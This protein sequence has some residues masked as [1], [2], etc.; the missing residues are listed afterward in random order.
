[1]KAEF[2]GQKMSTEMNDSG[3]AANNK[4]NYDRFGIPHVQEY[5]SMLYVVMA[6]VCIIC[7]LLM[8]YILV[9]MWPELIEL[10][11]EVL[12]M[13]PKLI[14]GALSAL[15]ILEPILGCSMPFIGSFVGIGS[16]V[17]YVK[18]KKTENLTGMIITLLLVAVN[19]GISAVGRILM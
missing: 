19:V 15:N 3:N 6:V 5:H 2:D 11:P 14:P 13:W 1:M 17:G 4:G 12:V 8:H 9:E 18:D 10:C 16:I 7:N